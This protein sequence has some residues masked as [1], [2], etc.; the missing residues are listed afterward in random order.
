MAVAR[1]VATSE[2]RPALVVRYGWGSDMP[3]PR[4]WAFAG[5][6]SMAT[7]PP[8]PPET[9]SDNGS[10]AEENEI[11]PPHNGCCVHS[12]ENANVSLL[13]CSAGQTDLS[14][15]LTPPHPVTSPA[16]PARCGLVVKDAQDFKESKAD[17]DH[18]HAGFVV[19]HA[20]SY[21]EEASHSRG[22]NLLSV[23]AEAPSHK[24]SKEVAITTEDDEK[25]IPVGSTCGTVGMR[26]RSLRDKGQGVVED[27]VMRVPLFMNPDAMKSQVR[28][29]LQKPTYDVSKFYHSSG[30]WRT[31]A[32]HPIFENLTLCVISV[33][34]LWIAIDTD[35][36]NAAVLNEAEPVFQVVEHTF[37]GYFSMEWFV[38]FMAFRR[39]KYGLRD[40][41]FV[42]DSVLVFMMV[43]ET[44]VMNLIFAIM[45]GSGSGVLGNAAILRLL[46][47]LR[48]SRLARMLR[49]MPELMILIKGMVSAARSLFFTMCLLLILIYVF[50]IALKQIAADTLPGKTYFPNIYVSMHSLLIHGTLLDNFDPVCAEIS[51]KAKS[52]DPKLESGSWF[53][54]LIFFLF[55]S[56]AALMVM[57]M[58]IGVLCEVVSAVAATEKEEMLVAFVKGRMSDVMS[59]IDQNGDLQ[60]SKKEFAEVLACDDALQVLNEVGVDPLALVDLAD[61][62]FNDN[63]GNEIH[64]TFSD[65]MEIVMEMRSSQGA[66][67]K[68]MMHLVKVVRTEMR[69]LEARISGREPI[70]KSVMRRLSADLGDDI[71]SFTSGRLQTDPQVTTAIPNGFKDSPPVPESQ[72][73][74]SQQTPV[75]LGSQAQESLARSSTLS[76]SGDRKGTE[77]V[78]SSDEN[79]V[80]PVPHLPRTEVVEALLLAA[81]GE[82][83]RGLAADAAWASQ[84][85]TELANGLDELEK[86]RAQNP[87]LLM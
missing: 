7:R 35:N 4:H 86:I 53:I 71:M 56:M 9:S 57:N 83:Q 42:F 43:V 6:G 77:S 30:F 69:K 67:V 66:T 58:L 10:D 22:S 85:A 68:D 12:C 65:F 33:N 20:V 32:T 13:R 26:R 14:S 23:P 48:L 19:P 84:L 60:I 51:G 15:L 45:G 76:G 55:V 3:D 8:P 72:A 70:R 24:A 28:E 46:R 34:A 16:P 64:L 38:R 49:S 59:T 80:S 39:K 37:C 52:T 47:L 18:D 75:A 81:H 44:W 61:F 5:G 17:C 21:V 41:W 54:L 63:D 50:A 27:P 11:S 1:T 31:W 29:A 82:L 73:P 79:A 74:P 25:I 78:G 62:I 40:A 87:R 36:N 2:D